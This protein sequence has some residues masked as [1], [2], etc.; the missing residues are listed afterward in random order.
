M[1]TYLAI[2]QCSKETLKAHWSVPVWR[3]LN[4]K[5]WPMFYLQRYICGP[6]NCFFPCHHAWIPPTHA[7][8]LSQPECI[9]QEC[10]CMLSSYMG[11]KHFWEAR[12][13]AKDWTWDESSPITE[14]TNPHCSTTKWSPAPLGIRLS[15]NHPLINAVR[16]C[17]NSMPASQSEPKPTPTDINGKPAIYF[18]NSR[19][20]PQICLHL[21]FHMQES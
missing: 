8:V 16:H 13:T 5:I 4:S 11:D 1:R 21:T 15:T 17:S 2:K 7:A 3:S 14:G 20:G 18:N 6:Q 19:I 9:H 12:S 10:V